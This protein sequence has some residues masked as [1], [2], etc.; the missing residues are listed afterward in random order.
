MTHTLARRIQLLGLL[1]A[2]MLLAPCVALR[3][4]APA[5]TPAAA[6]AESAELEAL[7][8]VVRQT[9]S[10][11]RPEERVLDVAAHPALGDER[12]RLTLIEFSDLQCQFCRR[13][14]NTVMPQ[15][16]SRHVERGAL[17]YVFF[18]YPVEARHSEAFGAAVSARCAADQGA[19]WQMRQRLYAMPGRDQLREHAAALGLDMAAFDACLGDPAKASAVRADQSLAESIGIRGTP[20]FLLGYRQDDS[21]QVR[22]L[23]RIVG[24]QPTEVFEAAIT[25]VLAEFQV[26]MADAGR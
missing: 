13:H 15:L 10:P 8:A 21:S 18:D 2:S 26:P 3:A 24:A 17:H 6:Q 12:A 7:R 1:A 9:Q 11:V 16:L 25:Q 4:D 14:V 5:G 22:V 23:R 20:T 19:Y